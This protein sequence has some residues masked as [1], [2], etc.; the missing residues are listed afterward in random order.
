MKS[1]KMFSRISFVITL[2][3]AFLLI[4]SCSKSTGY[5]S[6]STTNMNPGGTTQGANDIWIQNMTFGPSSKTVA[7]GTTITWTNLDNVGH[8]VISTSGAFGSSSLGTGGTFSFT[9]NVAG[10][11]NYYCSIHPTMTGTIIVQ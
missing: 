8:T 10:T 6:P 5:T 1:F 11:F 7:A 3:S 9:F 4:T 2:F